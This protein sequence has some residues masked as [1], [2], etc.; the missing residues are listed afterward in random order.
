MLLPAD[1][2]VQSQVVWR[3]DMVHQASA[4]LQAWDPQTGDQF[5]IFPTHGFTWIEGGVTFFPQGSNY[6][7]NEVCP[8]IWDG[9]Q[10]IGQIVFPRFRGD[11]TDARIL[12]HDD[13]PRVG[14]EAAMAAAEPGVQK[15]GKAGRVRIAYRTAGYAVEE[16]FHYVI[17]YALPIPGMIPASFWGPTLLSSMRATTGRADRLA[18]LHQAILSSVRLNPR[19]MC[20]LKQVQGMFIQNQI[21]ASRNAMRLSRYI[22]QVN[23]EIMEMNR[24]SFEAQQAAHDRINQRFDEY[25]RG[26]ETYVDPSSGGAGVQLPSGYQQAWTNGLGEYVVSDSYNFDPNQ[27]MNGNWQRMQKVN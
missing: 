14:Q 4:F 7:G 21:N 25:I 17:V 12:A 8:P 1:W 2:Q 15:L 19:W 16:D 10:F 26:V 3:Y 9:A 20:A 24:Q 22:A 23:D 6:C 18:R 5:T 27:H 13:Y 11:A